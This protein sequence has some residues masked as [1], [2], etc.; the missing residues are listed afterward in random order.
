VSATATEE[1]T[2]SAAEPT[3]GDVVRRLD[4]IEVNLDAILKS[5]GP[6]LP[7][8]VGIETASQLY[9]LSTDAL[10]RLLR[11][12]RLRSYRP[13]PAGGKILIERAELEQLIRDSAD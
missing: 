13:P 2:V 10:R 9:G 5:R 12:G 3:L 4:T 6:L 11:S 8:Y 7:R 1:Q